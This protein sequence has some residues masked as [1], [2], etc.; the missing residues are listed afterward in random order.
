MLSSHTNKVYYIGTKVKD[1]KTNQIGTV[2]QI[3]ILGSNGIRV[4]FNDTT[5][6]GYFGI[7]LLN[8][9]IIS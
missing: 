8:L 7:Q 6:K 1:L 4:V 3:N 5:K 2:Y 9:E